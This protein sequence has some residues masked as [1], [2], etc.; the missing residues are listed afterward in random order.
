MPRTSAMRRSGLVG[1]SS[2]TIVTLLLP[3]TS[4]AATA[5]RLVVSTWRTSCS[6]EGWGGRRLELGQDEVGEESSAPKPRE[7][8]KRGTTTTHETAVGAG[9]AEQAVAAAVDVVAGEDRLPGLDEAQDQVERGHARVDDVS[10]R[11]ARDLL[12]V[13]LWHEGNPALSVSLRPF[14][15]ASSEPGPGDA[16]RNERVGLPERV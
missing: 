9:P 15:Q 4:S 7:L 10:C 8:D 16:P 12:Q 13:V 11:R 1:D 3:G 2:R 5:S 14:A 6:E